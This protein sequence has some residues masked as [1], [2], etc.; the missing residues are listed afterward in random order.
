MIEALHGEYGA[1]RPVVD[2][3]WAEHN[4]QVGSTG[5]TVAPKLY[6]ACGISGA[7][8]HLA[9]MK[10]SEFVVAINT[11]KDAPTGEVADVLVVADLKQFI[12]AL[13]ERAQG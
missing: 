5:Q 2:A 4:R 9:G 12:P 10:K 6:V 8:Q 3:G 7:I 11:D 13:T 1:S